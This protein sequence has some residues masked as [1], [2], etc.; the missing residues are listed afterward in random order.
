MKSFKQ[1]TE[2]LREFATD[3]VRKIDIGNNLPPKPPR[4]GGDGGRRPSHDEAVKIVSKHFQ[5]IH[6]EKPNIS[7]AGEGEDQVSILHHP[8]IKHEYS[9]NGDGHDIAVLK[10]HPEHGHTLYDVNWNMG[11]IVKPKEK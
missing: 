2:Y 6:G 3:K 5:S 10:S 8:D 4:G 7:S 11:T 9:V 1:F